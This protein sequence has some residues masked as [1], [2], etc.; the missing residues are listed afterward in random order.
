MMSTTNVGTVKIIRKVGK[1]RNISQLYTKF[2]PIGIVED[3]Y[4]F[5][6][7][8]KEGSEAMTMGEQVRSVSESSAKKKISYL[9]RYQGSL[10]NGE[11]NRMDDQT[12]DNV[13]VNTSDMRNEYSMSLYNNK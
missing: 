6:K 1:E 11:N 4:N 8:D 7:V 12:L 10:I 2:T 13:F 5:K 9:R 3:A